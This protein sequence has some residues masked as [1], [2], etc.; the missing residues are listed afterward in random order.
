ALGGAAVLACAERGVPVIAVHNPCVLE[1]NAEA[2]GLEVLQARS[3]S[4]AAGLVLT[5]REGIAPAAL[6]RPLPPLRLLQPR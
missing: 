5:L 6:Q 2:L 4:E 1:V 3:Y